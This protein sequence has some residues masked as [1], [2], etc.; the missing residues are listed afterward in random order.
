MPYACSQEQS[1]S[2]VTAR[3]SKYTLGL[4]ADQS[5]TRRGVLKSIL[6]LHFQQSLQ[7]P[8]ASTASFNVSAALRFTPSPDQTTHATPPKHTAWYLTCCSWWL[9][10]NLTPRV[11]RMLGRA[12]RA[13]QARSCTIHPPRLCPTVL[14]RMPRRHLLRVICLPRLL[15]A[16]HACCIAAPPGQVALY[17][18]DPLRETF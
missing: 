9:V 13:V 4:G 16:T 14:V 15:L 6:S 7:W 10:V 18:H 2:T 3:V 5:W 8:A 17:M 11:R 1:S 12:Q